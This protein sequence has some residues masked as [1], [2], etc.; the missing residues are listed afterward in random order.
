[1]TSGF[2]CIGLYGNNSL[3]LF[4][5]FFARD[6]GPF[7]RHVFFFAIPIYTPAIILYSGIVYAAMKT[8]I[9]QWSHPVNLSP[10]IKMPFLAYAFG[11]SVNLMILEILFL[12][13]GMGIYAFCCMLYGIKVEEGIRWRIRGGLNISRAEELPPP[14]YKQNDGKVK[15]YVNTPKYMLQLF[16]LV[17]TGTLTTVMTCLSFWITE[18]TFAIS[19][20]WWAILFCLYYSA[21]PWALTFVIFGFFM[22]IFVHLIQGTF[23]WE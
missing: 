13:A 12:I 16:T 14:Y 3:N 1:M 7:L 6:Y 17:F 4:S 8:L 20:E 18:D 19:T 10:D 11:V 23:F 21:T 15:Y 2:Y 9:Y 22:S 5:A